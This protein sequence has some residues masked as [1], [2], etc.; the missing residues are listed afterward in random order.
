MRDLLPFMKIMIEQFVPQ[1]MIDEIFRVLERGSST[2]GKGKLTCGKSYC[3]YT[4]KLVKHLLRGLLGF[5]Y[6]H[7][8]GKS[9]FAH[10]VIRLMQLWYKWRELHSASFKEAIDNMVFSDTDRLNAI[11]N[12]F[13]VSGHQELINGEWIR[14]WVCNYS[15]NFE[16]VTR[17]SLREVLDAAIK[18]N[19]KEAK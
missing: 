12:G 15:G 9:H 4:Y 17:S 3:H 11:D 8:S 19:K 2:E 13:C 18:L 7:D 5:K 14:K 10:A 16:T 1:P 6:D